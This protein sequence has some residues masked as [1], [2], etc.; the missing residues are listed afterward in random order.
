MELSGRDGIYYYSATTFA[1]AG[2]FCPST[3][4]NRTFWPSRRVLKPSDCIAEKWTKTSFPSSDSIKPK[5]LDSLNHFTVPSNTSYS[6]YS[7][8]IKIYSFSWSKKNAQAVMLVRRY[9]SSGPIKNCTTHNA[10]YS[11]EKKNNSNKIVCMICES[12]QRPGSE[13]A[14]APFPPHRACCFF[15]FYRLAR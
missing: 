15:C 14:A 9:S 13:T 1:A 7:C 6:L 3:I 5:P 11:T 4:S 8:E 2:P 10:N 12:R